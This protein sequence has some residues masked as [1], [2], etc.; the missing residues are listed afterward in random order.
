MAY[1]SSLVEPWIFDG[2]TNNLGAEVE[3][4]VLKT[5]CNKNKVYAIAVRETHDRKSSNKYL[6]F[7]VSGGVGKR[8]STHFR[9]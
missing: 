5:S 4:G 9:N 1:L 2:V 6:L 8:V 7:F 3:S